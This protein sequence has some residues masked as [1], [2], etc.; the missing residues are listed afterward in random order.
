MRLKPRFNCCD[1]IEC[2]VT[3]NLCDSNEDITASIHTL[4]GVHVI[5]CESRTLRDV[6]KSCTSIELMIDDFKCD[7]R[8]YRMK[9]E[10]KPFFV[11]HF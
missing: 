6:N 3:S 4:L 2:V 5:R 8:V 9:S 11:W 1:E 10:N 7:L